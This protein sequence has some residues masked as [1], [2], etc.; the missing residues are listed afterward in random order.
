MS[1]MEGTMHL[2]LLVE[3]MRAEQLMILIGIQEKLRV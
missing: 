3:R 1:V 2:R